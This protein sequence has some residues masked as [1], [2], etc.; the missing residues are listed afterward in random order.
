MFHGLVLD[1]AG[2]L[3][4]AL[5]NIRGFYFNY[6]NILRQHRKVRRSALQGA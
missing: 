3:Q 2:R 6:A 5:E 1:A 4:G